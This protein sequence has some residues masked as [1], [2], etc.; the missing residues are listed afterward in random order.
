MPT[1]SVAVPVYR[2]QLDRTGSVPCATSRCETLRDAVD[3]VREYLGEPD[4]EHFVTVYMD[5]QLEA[6][7]VHTVAIGDRTSIHIT[8]AEVFK[9]GLLCNAASVILAHNHPSGQLT[10]SVQ[11]RVITGQLEI[12][13][14]L[15]GMTVI[16][17]IILGA[18]G[19]VSMRELGLMSLPL[20]KAFDCPAYLRRRARHAQKHWPADQV[21]QFL[22]L[23]AS[24]AEWRAV[25]IEEL[26]EHAAERVAKSSLRAVALE[27]GIGRS[28]LFTFLK[29]ES[30]TVHQRTRRQLAL[31]Y[32]TDA[33]RRD[34]RAAALAVLLSGIT[35]PA[36]HEAAEAGLLRDLEEHYV[37]AGVPAPDWIGRLRSVSQE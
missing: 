24:Q 29:L 22:G 31:W 25:P 37:R 18:P 35:D 2:V 7:A 11:D 26:R 32:L 20:D 8:A 15:L 27:I 17:H 13:G 21:D 9:V 12:A 36:A 10:P 16:D 19:A 4:R 14:E 23:E 28:T 6:I 30:L 5:S 1:S 33:P 34:S 3:L